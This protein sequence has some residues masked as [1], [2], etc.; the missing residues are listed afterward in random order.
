MRE[1]VVIWWRDI[2]AQVQVRAGRERLSEHLGD[3]FEKAID[4][5]AM[6]ARL[7]GTD[8]YLQQWRRESKTIGEGVDLEKALRE[9]CDFLLSRYSEEYLSLLVE[10]KGFTERKS[11]KEPTTEGVI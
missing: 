3:R 7:T 6:R 1:L 9:K 8:G 11:E 5:A 10:N 2:P 4:R